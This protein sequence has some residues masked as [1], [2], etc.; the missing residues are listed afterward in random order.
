MAVPSYGPHYPLI[1]VNRL[2][3]RS[4]TQQDVIVLGRILIVVQP[5]LDPHPSDRIGEARSPRKPAHFEFG[6]G[7]LPPE[8]D[9]P[10]AT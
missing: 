2:L 10:Q 3:D 6:T 9:A 1:Q 4:Y 7:F 8:T 5:V